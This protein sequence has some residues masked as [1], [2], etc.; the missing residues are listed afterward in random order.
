MEAGA[1]R[2]GEE[3]GDVRICGW[4]LVQ[5]ERNALTMC[6]TRALTDAQEA[7]SRDPQAPAQGDEAEMLAVVQKQAAQ[8]RAALLVCPPP[9]PCSS[10]EHPRGNWLLRQ[11][12]VQRPM[13]V[14]AQGTCALMCLHTRAGEGQVVKEAGRVRPWESQG[15]VQGGLAFGILRIFHGKTA[16][17]APGPEMERAWLLL[18]L[19]HD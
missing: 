12:L 14:F 3:Q 2:A 7:V 5:D 18:P 8:R 13:Q 10:A 16:C 6:V 9:R 19:Y 11:E 4:H 17:T 1:G 15:R